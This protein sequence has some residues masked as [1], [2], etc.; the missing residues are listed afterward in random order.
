MRY[1]AVLLLAVV[2]HAHGINGHVHVTGWA[3]DSLP[4]G[5]LRDFFAEREVRDAAMIGASFP[6][7]GYAVDDPYGE[8]AHWEPFVTILLERLRREVGPPF[9]TLEARK[10][11]AFMMGLAA[12]GMQDELF[13]SVFLHQVGE[14]D[15][16]GQDEADP[17]TDAFLFTDGHLRWKPPLFLPAANLV[18]AF[19]DAHGH[20]VT[21]RTMDTGMRRVKLLVIDGFAALAPGFDEQYRP[22]IPWAAAHYMDPEVPGSLAAEIPATRAYLEALWGRLHDRYPADGFVG[23]T[24]PRTA[25]RLR[26]NGAQHVDSWV[27]VVFGIG[28]IRGSLGAERVAWAGPEG[29]V[30]F[31]LR[32]TRWSG[33]P[34]DSTRL[35]QLR[36]RED[37]APD[38]EYTIT[39]EAGVTL[40]D[41]RVTEAPWSFSFHTACDVEL[42]CAAPDAG[43]PLLDWSVPDAAPP[44]AAPPDAAPP[45]PDT[46]RADAP[47][48]DMGPVDAAA[49][50]A[51]P[52]LDA[53]GVA[54]DATPIDRSNGGS[55][56]CRSAP[57][58]TKLLLSFLFFLAVGRKRG[59]PRP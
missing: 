37:L 42:G 38:T 5:E 44:D 7:S 20:E 30:P 53:D 23:H 59:D 31:D 29:P 55:D 13:D 39:I 26:G 10:E 1:L 50:D 16:A 52:M 11:A 27:T 8:L 35:V 34:D 54:A 19:R 28:A 40:Q 57:A 46:G 51:A 3:I 15:D 9:D 45:A 14:H 33:S 18:A 56:G 48:P 21:E 36:P 4:A 32:Y 47:R 41:G 6:D 24:W 43:P 25:R 22:L 17:G 58:P 12:H 49:F 2:G